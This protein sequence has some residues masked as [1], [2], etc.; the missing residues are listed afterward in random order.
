MKA[1]LRPLAGTGIG[2]F[3]LFVMALIPLTVVGL[4]IALDTIGPFF[5][6]K[7][8]WFVGIPLLVVRWIL[9]V[10]LIFMVFGLLWFV[11]KGLWNIATRKPFIDDAYVG[12]EQAPQPKLSPTPS[13]YSIVPELD[14]WLAKQRADVEI[15]K[16]KVRSR[17]R[18]KRAN[19]DE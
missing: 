17:R 11:V 18:R 13:S 19:A 12:E 4:I 2:L 6:D 9:T 10:G 14:A 16:P 7:G 8:W 15:S 1:L 5:F 3:I